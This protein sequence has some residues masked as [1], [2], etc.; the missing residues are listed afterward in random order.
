MAAYLLWPLSPLY[1]TNLIP[2]SS[3]EIA[4]TGDMPDCWDQYLGPQNLHDWYSHWKLDCSQAYEGTK[5]I[6]IRIDDGS[7]A[8]KIFLCPSWSRKTMRLAGW[9]KIKTGSEYTLSV[10]MKSDRD[11]FPVNVAFPDKNIVC[12]T[13]NWKRYVFH[14]MLEQ[15]FLRSFKI[16][17]LGIGKLWIDAMQMEPGNAVSAYHHSVCDTDLFPEKAPKDRHEI[18]DGLKSCE[19]GHEKLSI[20]TGLSYYTTEPKA[21]VIVSVPQSRKYDNG[22]TFTIV[23]TPQGGH[24]GETVFQ[25][26]AGSASAQTILLPISALEC[27]NYILEACIRDKK[28]HVLCETDAVLTKLPPKAHEVKIDTTRQTLVV[29]GE[30]FFLFGTAFLR[31][32]L[33]KDRIDEILSDIH[34]KGYTTVVPTFASRSSCEAATREDVVYFFETAS[35]YHLKVIPWI[36]ARAFKDHSGHTVTVRREKPPVVLEHYKKEILFLMNTIKDHP[37]LLAWYLYDEPYRRDLINY[38]FTE[39]ITGYARKLDPYHPV[40]INYNQAIKDELNLNNGDIPGDIVSMTQYPVPLKPLSDSAE[41]TCIESIASHGYKPVLVWLQFW[42]GH[43]RYPTAREFSCMVYLSAIYGATGFYTWPLMPGS[44]NLWNSIEENIDEMKRLY[45]VILSKRSDVEISNPSGTIHYITKEHMG[46]LYLIAANASARPVQSTFT[47]SPGSAYSIHL[48]QGFFNHRVVPTCDRE[49][50]ETIE[51]FGHRVYE[52][53]IRKHSA[54][55]D[56]GTAKRE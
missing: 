32:H 40:Y 54:S 51:G 8:G 2:N 29:Q 49:F 33:Y 56:H 39:K 16:E 53:D 22:S 15:E 30:P 11:E 26:P 19:S 46:K 4:T 48:V 28:K 1:C 44:L 52:I 9:K 24:S 55:G 41:N 42:S 27:G 7:Q 25:V 18:L 35:K 43:G 21:G 36:E 5:S 17:P 31:A 23:M 38:Q 3:F 34:A 14:G 13:K 37:A 20:R 47:L 6:L 50:S 10:Y 45:P 12:L